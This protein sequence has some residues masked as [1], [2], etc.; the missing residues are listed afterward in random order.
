MNKK[1]RPEEDTDT[2]VILLGLLAATVYM[3]CQS[4]CRR[5]ILTHTS[6]KPLTLKLVVKLLLL[7]LLLLF[8]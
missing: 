1:V 3:S 6:S 8:L 7:L 2:A 4:N 5:Q